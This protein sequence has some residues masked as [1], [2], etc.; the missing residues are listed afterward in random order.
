MVSISNLIL[1]GQKIA[2]LTIACLGSIIGLFILIATIQLY[3][4]YTSEVFGGDD[5]LKEGLMI[6]KKVNMS[7]TLTRKN[8]SFTDEEID[9]ITKADFVDDYSEVQSSRFKVMFGMDKK[10]GSLADF[11]LLFFVQSLPDKFVDTNK[12]KFVWNE[13]DS[14]VP[15]IIP[16]DYLN[17]LNSGFAISQGIPQIPEEMLKEFEINM[18]CYGNNN[19][20]KFKCKIVGFTASLNSILVPDNFLTWANNRFDDKQKQP[21]VSRIYVVANSEKH[22]ELV[23]LLQD[24]KYEVNDSKKKSLEDKAKLQIIISILVGLGIIILTLSALSFVQY[25]QLIILNSEYEI[26]V[27]TNIGYNYKYLAKHYIKFFGVIFICISIIAFIAAII[28]KYWFNGWVLKKGI[29]VEGGLSGITYLIG[30]GFLVIYLLVNSYVIYSSI[31][32]IA[33]K[34]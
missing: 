33:I 28:G 19:E 2:Q 29:V 30:I 21:E 23:H 6:S 12:D 15:L 14:L 1:K 7:N 8:A 18:R 16:L 11:S 17:M 34:N 25:S 13:G 26:G 22:G 27:L 3:L 32:K 24:D 9:L 20:S 4:V 5:M 10:S 31:K